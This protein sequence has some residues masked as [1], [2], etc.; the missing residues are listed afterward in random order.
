[1]ALLDTQVG[2]LA[3][4]AMNYLASGVTPQ[5]MGNAHP[6]S[7]PIR[8]SRSPTGISS[9]PSATTGSSPAL[10]RARRAG[11]RRR[12]GLPATTT[13]VRQSHRADRAPAGLLPEVQRDALLSALETVGVPSGPINEL[14]QVFADPQV[15]LAACSS[16]SPTQRRRGA[17][18]SGIRTR[19]CSTATRWRRSAPAPRLGE[20]TAEILREIGEAVIPGRRAAASPESITTER[21]TS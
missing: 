17:A 4:Q 3:N 14:D 16:I 8:C 12:P 9:S 7:C 18:I 21:A 13:R 2:V 11:T 6:T 20:H 5:R 1:M 15:M 10:Q 19:S